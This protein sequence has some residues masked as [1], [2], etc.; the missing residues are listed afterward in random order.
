MY[1][2]PS[3][4]SFAATHI[5]KVLLMFFL[6]EDNSTFDLASV[7]LFVNRVGFV[8]TSC[9]ACQQLQHQKRRF[10][11]VLSPVAPSAT[12]VVA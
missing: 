2:T 5:G 10:V 11:L 6:F 12:F 3:F 4:G 9:L 1:F 7:F 8:S